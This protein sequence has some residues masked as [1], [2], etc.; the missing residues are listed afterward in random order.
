LRTN[1]GRVGE[2]AENGENRQRGIGMRRWGEE[3]ERTRGGGGAERMKGRIIII[4]S[5]L[6]SATLRFDSAVQRHLTA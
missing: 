3:R 1:W 6:I 5:A 2:K 4:I